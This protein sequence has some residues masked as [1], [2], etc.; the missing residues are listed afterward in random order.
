[1]SD[2]K[3]WQRW[4]RA[5]VFKVLNDHFVTTHS[6]DQA[7]VYYDGLERRTQDHDPTFELRMDGPVHTQVDKKLRYLDIEINILIQTVYDTTDLY[8]H[9]RNVGIAFDILKNPVCAYKYGGGVDDD[10]SLWTTYSLWQ[11]PGKSKHIK[12]SHF[13]QVDVGVNVQQSTIEAPYRALLEF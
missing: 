12:T 2:A 9:D 6:V 4:T 13:G 3:H 5:S 10:D 11:D 7:A 8:A 1:M